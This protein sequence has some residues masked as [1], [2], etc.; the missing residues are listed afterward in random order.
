[1]ASGVDCSDVY[2]NRK[3][4]DVWKYFTKT[5]DKKKAI[6]S[7]C[8]K[9]LAY[10]GGT[11]NL[12]DHVSSKHPLQYFPAGK[13]ATGSKTTTLD[14]FV[15]PSK[16]SEARAKGITDRVSQMIV[17]D[18]R[19]IR[20]VECEGFRNLLSYLE[21]G[22]TLPSRKQFN[23]DIN[24]KFEACK[25]KLKKCLEAEA[26]SM[27]LT[28][29]IWTSMATE[30]YM[31]VTAHYIDPNLKLQNFVLET[32]PFP[33]RHTDV[34]V[35]E[36]L[37][38]VGERWGITH[39]VIIVN[40]DQGSN[41]EAA[42]EILTEECNWQSLACSAHRLQLCILAG[43]KVNAIDKLTAAVKKI[44]SHFSHSVVATE[45]LKNKQQQMNITA[46]KLINSCPNQVEFHI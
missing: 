30:A 7:I 39:K 16:C 25:D 9:E 3:I 33:E 5:P 2:S 6:C 43:L 40:H 41:M 14:G 38:G 10:S 24:H 12:R 1:M 46:K 11:T 20:L 31:T 18:L 45:A 37:K 8:H 29:N 35:A 44:V 13:T 28:T 42:M 21:P 22:Y 27:A 4:S 23:M 36:K 17:Q 26:L 15:R 19:P 32:F 34:N